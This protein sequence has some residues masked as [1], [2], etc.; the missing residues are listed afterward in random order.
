[1]TLENKTKIL[2]AELRNVALRQRRNIGVANNHS[3][4]V[5][6]QQCA[7]YLQQCCL[8]GTA[9]ANYR[10]YLALF[11]LQIDAFQHLNIAIRFVNICNLYHRLKMNV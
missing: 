1:M 8:S 4:T 7:N 3:P 11:H 9:L 10:H 2:I 6:T 5:G